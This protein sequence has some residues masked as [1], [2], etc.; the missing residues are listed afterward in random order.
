MQKKTLRL[1]WDTAKQFPAK[2]AII[3]I[4]PSLTVIVTSFVGPFIIAQFLE[5]LQAGTLNVSQS[6]PLILAYAAVQLY[7]EVI[8]WRITLYATWTMQTAA[9][10]ILYHKIF[11]HL[12]QQ[13]LH[14][15][16]ERFGGSMVSQ[17]SKLIGA[18]ERFWDTITFQFIPVVTSVV[19]A[20]TILSFLFWQYAVFLGVLS[21]VFILCIVYGS[22]FMATFNTLEAQAS[23]TLT[24]RLADT[25]TNILALKSHG[26]E[27][28]EL[29][30]YDQLS[31]QWR[32]RSL[33][34]MH[35]FLKVSTAYS[36]LI[37]FINITALILAV[38]AAERQL[39]SIAVVYLCVTYTFTVARQLWEMNSIM[40][41]FNRVIGDSHD[42]TEILSLS[43][44][45]QDKIPAH[46]FSVSKG[47]IAFAMSFTHPESGDDATLFHDFKLS[48][49]PKEKI[50]LVGHSGS[51]K[52]TLTK[53][54]LRFMDVDAGAIK[55]DGQDIKSVA[56]TDLRKAIAYVP[57]E[58]LLF[59]RSLK[60]NI[61]YGQ[62]NATTAEINEAARKAHALEFIEKLPKKFETTVGERG[63]KLSGGQ[64][65]RIAIAR[66]ILKNAPILVLDEATSAL[67]S[68]SEH[69]IQD[70]LRELMEDR[71][72]I[73]IAHR[74]STVQKMDRIIVL[75][76]GRIV[77]QGSHKQLLSK[78]GTYAN[79]WRHQSGGFIEE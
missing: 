40:R 35:G 44:H 27:K 74:L 55:I 45:I 48:I 25:I 36:S 17:S 60:E 61:A 2:L 64:R 33:D 71:T 68:E 11:D 18:F 41:H 73:V 7:G 16:S 76:N 12:M 15:H 63:V 47:A 62:A 70:A 65:Q 21:T 66:A 4:N 52:T 8:G 13:S 30:H 53:L 77:E 43:P 38:I 54:L 78:N 32:N 22:R 3:L 46:S 58:P 75:D 1:F 56:Q 6:M 42:M 79:L 10:R 37:A 50:G 29:N 26:Q 49:A 31:S 28:A 57:Q 69:L 23:S 14:F 5:Q 67:D 19:A 51:G 72:A 39:I 24:G 34:T 59:H 9:Q 20:I